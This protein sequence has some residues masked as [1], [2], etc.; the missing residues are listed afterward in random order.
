MRTRPSVAL[1]LLAL[2]WL[3]LALPAQADDE[4]ACFYR[5]VSQ[6]DRVVHPPQRGDNEF[7]TQSDVPPN[8]LW[9]LDNSGS[10][11]TLPCNGDCENYARCGSGFNQNGNPYFIQR[12]YRPYTTDANASDAFDPD[13]CTP[14]TPRGFNGRDGC[15][16]PGLVYRHHQ[17]NVNSLCG[18]WPSGANGVW[19]RTGSSDNAS[20]PQS[21]CNG[22]YS[23]QSQRTACVQQLLTY[24]YHPGTNV[25]LPVF[26]GEALNVYPPK[27]VVARRVL[28]DLVMD[29]K[30]IR[31]GLMIFNN[32]GAGGPSG[33]GQFNGGHLLTEFGPACN[34]FFPPRDS[35]FHNN[36]VAITNRIDNVRFLGGTPLGETLMSACQYV[37]GNQSR[38]RNEV[39]VHGT[40][41][42]GFHDP[43]IPNRHNN[44]DPVCVSCQRNMIVVIT[45][46]LPSVD[47]L[48]PCK[49]RNYDGDCK[50][51]LQPS[52]S[53]ATAP[54]SQCHPSER[55]TYPGVEPSDYFDDVAAFCY[56]E[57]LRPDMPGKQNAIIYT[58][59]FDIDAPILADAAEKGGGLYLKANDASELRTALST[60][61]SDVRQRAT[62]F[63]VASVT[64]V[65][66][67][68]STY[69]FVPRFRPSADELWEGHLYR[70]HFFNEFAAGCTVADTVGEMTA[71]KLSRNPN[72][73][74]DCDDVYYVD[75]LGRFVG[76]G[77]DGEFLVLDTTQS[78][79]EENG[80]PPAAPSTPA[81]PIWD[82]AQKLAT[83][84][85]QNDP[86]AIYTV[87]DL[88]EDGVLEPG[89]LVPFTVDNAALLAPSLAVGSR[90]G[91]V[92]ASMASR[93]GAAYATDLDCVRD[94]IRFVR[95][96]DV[97]DEDRDG[98]TTEPRRKILGDIFHSAPILVTPPAPR[99]LC[100]L[101]ILSQCTFALYGPG[102][103]PGGMGAYD[104]YAQTYEERDQFILVGA[105]DGMLHAFQAG[106][107]QTG[108]DPSTPHEEGPLHRY[109]DLGTGRELWAFIPPDL[110][111]KLHL[112]LQRTGRHEFFVD[113][114]AMVRDVWVDS[115]QNP[116]RKDAGEFRTLA[117]V[118]ERQGGRS[119]FALDVTEPAAPQFRWIHP[120]P[121]APSALSAGES[122]ND[123]SPA[124][125]P[126]GPVALADTNGPLMV[127]GQPAR[128]QWAVF[129][130]GGYDPNHVRGR[131][132]TA[133]D[134]WTG[135]PIWRFAAEDASSA[136]DPRARLWPVA[137]PVALLDL[138][139]EGLSGN[140]DGLFDTAVVGDLLG[141]VWTFRFH[142]PGV[143]DDGDG[144]V[145]N[146]HGGRAFVQFKNGPL[147]NRSPF[148]QLAEVT[149]DGGT[150]VARVHVGSGDRM[151][152]R[153]TGDACGPTNLGECI[154]RN[155]RTE[156][157]SRDTVQGFEEVGATF[158]GGWRQMSGG[159]A[160]AYDNVALTPGEGGICEAPLRAGYQVSLQCGGNSGTYDWGLTCG[161]NQEDLDACSEVSHKPA[162]A[163]STLS[164]V[165]STQNAR[166]YTF[167]LYGGGP[168]RQPFRTRL[169]AESY[170]AAALT[171]ADLVPASDDLPA[172]D[173]GYYIAYDGSSER[174]SSPA[175]VLSGCV[176][177]NTL[178]PGVD[179][180]ACGG[181]IADKG[182]LYRAHFRDGSTAC[183][184]LEAGPRFVARR[185]L[186]APPAP[187]P[188]VALNPETG[189]VRYNMISV[190][191]GVPPFQTQVGESELQGGVYWLEMTRDI[192]Q[193]R[194]TDAA[195][196]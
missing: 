67:R 129:L 118:G 109:H 175:T 79:D 136:A 168:T 162:P 102:L 125:P 92:C 50:E 75:A 61:L 41:G 117:V 110:L 134:V 85:L 43:Q 143:D 73:D 40:L 97:F 149:V 52:P 90:H 195:C 164:A 188:T 156:V 70:L 107:H 35:N 20:T 24:G 46:G 86:R 139:G 44:Q 154:R 178:D 142:T 153:D 63:S 3:A 191:P 189:E 172:G 163:L 69:A 190:D 32:A 147:R 59:G 26:M 133:L 180:S 72:G 179:A 54:S 183:G 115:G 6:L 170:D 5:K 89:E 174:T 84:D 128:E 22:R 37:S 31:Q 185:A 165:T 155:C 76:E 113:G 62:S 138:A 103:T 82:A 146:W 160:L 193:C 121:G 192:H 94:V 48:V 108:D 2:A 126:I 120:P 167:P 100:D 17:T 23:Q 9:V 148:F 83:R 34:M 10:M 16:R 173:V 33:T 187:T 96:E 18:T 124:A 58:V 196:R 144:L 15:Y 19:V 8:L 88:D 1:S 11:Q 12:G 132:V 74:G 81:V 55:R 65:Q 57:D 99:Y 53:C 38:F 4:V 87:V 25:R 184:S 158:Q 181:N 104:E 47:T 27:F 177:W 194:H 135:R 78:F 161:A 131:N 68:G 28:K 137:A 152:I 93:R 141:Q 21:Y 51:G 119:Y 169:E 7:F 130:G 77:A 186:S 140:Q 64:T 171:D 91:S 36:R 71:D 101:G 159:G 112:L 151:N 166:F 105:N 66:T 98:N 13:F 116:G 14:G 42:V 150:G 106:S 122:W 80:W 157:R 111:P 45:D 30:T 182:H 145:D 123:I 95:G 114:T 60:V 49:L 39:Q 127:D 176:V 56:A 29:T